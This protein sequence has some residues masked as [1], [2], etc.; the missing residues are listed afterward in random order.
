[1]KHMK[2]YKIT[3]TEDTKRMLDIIIREE[4]VRSYNAAIK[5]LLHQYFGEKYFELLNQIREEL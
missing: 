2:R 4:K 1:M 5:F 3:I